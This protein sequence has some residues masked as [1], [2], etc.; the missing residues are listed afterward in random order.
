MND[1]THELQETPVPAAEDATETLSRQPDAE[2]QAM[3]RRPDAFLTV[4]GARDESV[5]RKSSGMDWVRPSDLFTQAGSR[6]AGRGIDFQAELA[7]RARRLS[8]QGVASSRR[9]VS[10][11]ARRLPPV[12]AFGTR[13]APES[14]AVRTG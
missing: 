5:G 9:A 12:T 14:A 1:P 7:R 11:R 4:P 13:S 6:A 3:L 2:K 10:E 8:V